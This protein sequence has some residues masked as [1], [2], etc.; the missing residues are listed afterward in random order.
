MS[1]PEQTSTQVL[2]D[3]S[4]V[5]VKAQGFILFFFFY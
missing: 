5:L 4:D 3:F 2:L 1:F